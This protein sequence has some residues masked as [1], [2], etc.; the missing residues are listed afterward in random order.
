VQRRRATTFRS[1]IRNT[2]HMRTPRYRDLLTYTLPS[3]PPSM[4]CPSDYCSQNSDERPHW[5]FIISGPCTHPAVP[6]THPGSHSHLLQ[7]LP[8]VPLCCPCRWLPSTLEF[9]ILMPHSMADVIMQPVFAVSRTISLIIGVFPAM[10]S[11]PFRNLCT[12]S[13]LRAPQQKHSPHPL[14][15]ASFIPRYPLLGKVG[16]ARGGTEGEQG[17]VQ[18]SR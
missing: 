6:V 8:H 11:V 18:T 12:L 15:V 14:T 10:I 2:K 13:F 16:E 1:Q 17:S 5:G 4:L 9:S 3:S 7:Y